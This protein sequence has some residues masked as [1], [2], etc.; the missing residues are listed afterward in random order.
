MLLMTLIANPPYLGSDEDEA[1]RSSD[2]RRSSISAVPRTA[3]CLSSAPP[4]Q[5]QRRGAIGMITMHAWMFLTF[6]PRP[7]R[8]RMPPP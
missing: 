8:P 4:P 3:R 2:T 5:L 6:L 7:F 1:I